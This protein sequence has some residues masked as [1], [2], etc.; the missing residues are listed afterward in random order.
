MNSSMLKSSFASSR[1]GMSLVEVLITISVIGVIT[2]MAIVSFD[3][4]KKEAADKARDKRN[5]QQLVTVFQ[6]GAAAGLDFYVDGDLEAT[7]DNVIAGATANEGIFDGAEFSL[8]GLE[9][10]AKQSA[11]N[12]LELNAGL[13]SYNPD[14]SSP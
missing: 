14:G 4:V 13:L 11:M 6:S 7:V 2:S 9:E 1:L 12:Y 10:S 8:K 5:A 3:A